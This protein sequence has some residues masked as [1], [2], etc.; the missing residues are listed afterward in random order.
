MGFLLVQCVASVGNFTLPIRKY[1]EFDFYTARLFWGPEK[2]PTYLLVDTGSSDT[3]VATSRDAILINDTRVEGTYDPSGSSSFKDLGEVFYAKYGD[4]SVAYGTYG[5]EDVTVNGITLKDF[6]FGSANKTN[7]GNGVFGIGPPEN[8]VSRVSVY[9]NFPIYLAENNLTDAAILN[10]D[11]G[12]G[13]LYGQLIFGSVDYE[14][15]CAGKRGI[16]QMGKSD[17]LFTQYLVGI[18][19]FGIGDD[20]L[21][22][23]DGAY[24]FFDTGNLQYTV[25]S[26]VFKS[27]G[28]AL[29]LTYYEGAGQYGI[30]CNFT[31]AP[32]FNF[33]GYE[34]TLPVESI[35]SK[36]VLYASQ[37]E[38]TLNLVE[39]TF[40]NVFIFG[41]E[42]I[43]YTFLSFDLKTGT[44]S[45][46]P[47]AG[48]SAGAFV[49]SPDLI[50]GSMYLGGEFS[51]YTSLSKRNVEILE[52]RTSKYHLPTM[53]PK[54]F[55][56]KHVKRGELTI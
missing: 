55:S 49:E 16:M 13:D 20:V 24:V 44:A 56:I 25:P 8:E 41:M 51:E 14:D 4:G 36:G 38:C 30:D 53:K 45:I 32:T 52:P 33:N 19:S 46:C 11:I 21:H 15:F 7:A 50:A 26:K 28:E 29:N 23:S 22:F 6:Q 34:F 1:P 3:W 43:E 40:E 2:I 37:G 47:S 31:G 27:I 48:S 54:D 17:G 10:I 18:S 5:T 12:K 9:A 35:I 39:S 42:F